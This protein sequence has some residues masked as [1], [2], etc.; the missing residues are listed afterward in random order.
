MKKTRHAHTKMAGVSP[1]AGG[2]NSLYVSV[3]NQEHKKPGS[4]QGEGRSRR[5]AAETAKESVS[6]ELQ[7]FPFNKKAPA[8]K[9]IKPKSKTK[10]VKHPLY[11]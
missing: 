4:G 8:S 9:A 10:A 5:R 2:L 1:V 3:G 6:A 7:P 11:G